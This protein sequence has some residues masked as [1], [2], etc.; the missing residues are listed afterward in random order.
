M[1]I[2]YTTSD[3]IRAALG[4]TER[5]I[6]DGQLTALN[7]ADQISIDLDE[8]Y[9]DHAA[10]EI[11]AAGLTPTD[12]QLRTFSLIKLYCQ[13]QGAVVVLPGFQNFIPQKLTDGGFEQQ[14]FEKDNIEKTKA[15][16]IGRRDKY[17]LALEQLIDPTATSLPSVLLRSIPDYDPVLNTGAT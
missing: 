16:I 9:P 5:E 14:R 2:L 11:A 6:S 1:D 7:T 3:S 8:V 12:L 15:E 13:Y 4:V 17:K 10:A